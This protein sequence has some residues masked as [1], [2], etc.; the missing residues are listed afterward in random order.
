MLPIRSAGNEQFKAL[1]KLVQSSRE[2]KLAGRSM[3][4]GVHLVAAYRDHMGVPEHVVVSNTG[5]GNPE[6]QDLLGR[7]SGLQPIVLDD[8]LFQKLSSVV[9]PT[10]IIAVI[11]T[12]RIEPQPEKIEACIMVEDLQDPGNLGSLLRSAAAAG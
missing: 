3:L 11:E 8:R 12:P 9:T 7:M 6:I 2:R 10:G 5:L 4:E 1:L